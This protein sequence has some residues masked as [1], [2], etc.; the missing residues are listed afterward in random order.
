MPVLGKIVAGMFQYKKVDLHVF[1]L[2]VLALILWSQLESGKH[3]S[4]RELDS[5]YQKCFY[6]SKGG[7]QHFVMIGDNEA[8]FVYVSISEVALL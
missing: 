7:I 3:E 6:S 1:V 2:A 8:E 5:G 4:S